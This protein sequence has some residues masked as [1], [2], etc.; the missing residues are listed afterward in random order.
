[1]FGKPFLQLSALVFT[2]DK[3]I[4]IRLLSCVFLIAT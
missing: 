2:G 1:M 4:I 3:D